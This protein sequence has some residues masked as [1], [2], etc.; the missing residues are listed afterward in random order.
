MWFLSLVALGM[1][2]LLQQSPDPAIPSVL[3]ADDDT[4]LEMNTI[5][6]SIPFLQR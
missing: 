2:Q 4:T 6:V 5:V 3:R 1:L